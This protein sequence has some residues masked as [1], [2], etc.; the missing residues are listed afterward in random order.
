MKKVLLTFFLIKSILLMAQKDSASHIYF[1]ISAAPIET[2]FHTVVVEN[3]DCRGVLTEG[4]YHTDFNIA[5][6]AMFFISFDHFFDISFGVMRD[7]LPYYRCVNI[8][9]I[10][11]RE[12]FNYYRY[13]VNI[14]YS[15]Y[16]PKSVQFFAQIGYRFFERGDY[17]VLEGL[18]YFGI[19][20]TYN[21]KH[22]IWFSPYIN[23]S[24]QKRNISDKVKIFPSSALGFSFSYSLFRINNHDKK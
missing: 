4:N 23:F 15:I 3:A 8:D 12:K 11:T 2:V 22:K 21:Q 19:G 5:S 6:G 14:K 24:V 20:A 9:G 7:I 16:K 17:V 1:G 13:P 10:F 18:G